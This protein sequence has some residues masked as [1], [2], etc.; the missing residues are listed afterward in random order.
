MHTLLKT[1]ACTLFLWLPLSQAEVYTW[2]NED[3]VR[4]YGDEPPASAKKADLP[5]IQS[6]PKEVFSKENQAK[7]KNEEDD[8]FTGYKSFKIISPKSDHTIQPGAAGS[9]SVELALRPAL[10]PGHEVTLFLDGKPVSSGAQ[11]HFQLT[12]L[13]RGSH[14]VHAHIKHEG[15]LLIS[16]SKRR[17]N[18][19]RP[20][21]LKRNRAQ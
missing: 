13:E 1:T 3:G 17:F 11:M 12:D 7:D 16:T 6:I 15:T 5:A 10:E 2:I 18:V 8:E 19:Q 9:L 4:V 20:S 14:L 21:I